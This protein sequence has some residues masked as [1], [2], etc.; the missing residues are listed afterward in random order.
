MND[1]ISRVPGYRR[2]LTTISRVLTCVIRSLFLL[3]FV[4]KDLLFEMRNVAASQYDPKKMPPTA[5]RMMQ[6]VNK[7]LHRRREAMAEEMTDALAGAAARRRKSR[8]GKTARVVPTASPA[9]T[10]AS[11]GRHSS[12]IGFAGGGD[13]DGGGSCLGLNLGGLSGVGGRATPWPSY[14]ACRGYIGARAPPGC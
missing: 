1:I 12:V 9:T 3:F 13:G 2:I 11:G 6:D 10:V 5:A 14:P 8:L 4:F 7:E